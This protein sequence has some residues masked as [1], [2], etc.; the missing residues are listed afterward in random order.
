MAH[1]KRKHHW[2]GKGAKAC[3]RR[4]A[5]CHRAIRALDAFNSALVTL[6]LQVTPRAR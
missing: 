1:K 6:A 4:I 5:Q 3:R 2:K